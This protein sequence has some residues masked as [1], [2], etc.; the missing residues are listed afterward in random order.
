MLMKILWAV[1]NARSEILRATTHLAGY[2]TKWTPLHDKKLHKLMPYLHTTQHYRLVGWVGDT[3][4][5]IQTHLFAEADLAG[6]PLTQRCA[7][8]MF[9]RTPY[10]I[11]DRRTSATTNMRVEINTRSGDDCNQKALATHGLP[12]MFL[13][14]YLPPHNPTLYFHE[15][16]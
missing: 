16:K 8:P 9:Q 3:P 4:D 12:G 14:E 5:Q 1:R 11:P 6:D 2:Q 13:W 7:I 15:D 10:L